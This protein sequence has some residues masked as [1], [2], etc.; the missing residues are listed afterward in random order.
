MNTITINIKGMTCNHCVM[1]VTKALNSLDGVSAAKVSLENNNAVVEFDENAV[2]YDAMAAAIADA[3]Y[4][5][6]G[7]A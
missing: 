6:L 4:E 3:G 2:N 1:R 5:A 7:T